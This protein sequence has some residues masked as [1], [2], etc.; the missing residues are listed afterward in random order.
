MAELD[1]RFIIA[2]PGQ[3]T[4]NYPENPAPEEALFNESLD[5]FARISVFVPHIRRLKPFVFGNSFGQFQAAV[6]AGV[7]DRNEGLELVRT[8]TKIVRQDENRREAENRDRTG[9]AVLLGHGRE[10]IEGLVQRKSVLYKT[11]LEMID[12]GKPPEDLELSNINGDTNYVLAGD[13][14]FL[15]NLVAFLDQSAGQA[16]TRARLLLIEGAYHIQARQKNSEEFAEKIETSG[17]IFRDPIYP[18]ISSTNPRVMTKGSEVK[19]EFVLQIPREVNILKVVALWKQ[20]MINTAVD[21]GPGQ[22]V[23]QIIKRAYGDGLWVMSL[24]DQ[25]PQRG[26][27]DDPLQKI[28]NL[29]ANFNIPHSGI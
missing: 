9:M 20:L 29:V 25:R 10:V 24:D 2:F 18:I 12:G 3:G 4:K 14:T 27:L 7:I 13:K 26:V 19:E 23:N 21:P 5:N 15:K 16:R 1:S 17:I 8:R 11:I 28:A 6:A 22:F